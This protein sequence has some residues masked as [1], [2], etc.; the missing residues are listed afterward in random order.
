M[1]NTLNSGSLESLKTGDVLLISA[2]KVE[3]GYI[4]LQYAEIIPTGNN[5]NQMQR[6]VQYLNMS[7]PKFSTRARRAWDSVSVEDCEKCFDL[8]FGDDAEWYATEKG[9]MIDLN[10]LNPE[11]PDGRVFKLWIQETT[12]ATKYQ[13]ENIETQAK[14]AGK[15]G[16]FI[17]HNGD[18]IYS[19]VIAVIVDKGYKIEHEFLAADTKSTGVTPNQGVNADEVVEEA[20]LEY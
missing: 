6:A 16:D 17:T 4:S 1:G 18:Y 13:S 3:N 2:R 19:N 15:D 9:E 20:N 14:R 7:N 8:N 10:I 12:K 5:S 11:T